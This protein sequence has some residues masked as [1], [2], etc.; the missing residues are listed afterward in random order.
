M[1]GG[2]GKDDYEGAPA[3][4]GSRIIAVLSSNYVYGIQD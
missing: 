3:E 4:D 2:G 1:E